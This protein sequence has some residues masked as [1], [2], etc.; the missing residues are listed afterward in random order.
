RGRSRRSH[1]SAGV[2]NRMTGESVPVFP[3]RFAGPRRLALL[4]ARPVRH[5]VINSPSPTPPTAAQR[6]ELWVQPDR[7]RDLYWG[8]GGQRLAPTARAPDTLIKIKTPA[9][10]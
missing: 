8:V 2:P 3:L 7:A 10:T 5:R 9:L 4:C 6:A 1:P